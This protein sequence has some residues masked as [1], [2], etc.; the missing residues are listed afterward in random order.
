MLDATDRGPPL[1]IRETTLCLEPNWH[2][3]AKRGL[4]NGRAVQIEFSF[5]SVPISTTTGEA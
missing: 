2:A 3:G 1:L 4:V 5:R